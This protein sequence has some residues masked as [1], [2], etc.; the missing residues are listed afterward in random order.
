MPD[1]DETRPETPEAKRLS[2]PVFSLAEDATEADLK[3]AM[4]NAVMSIASNLQYL[5][6]DAEARIAIENVNA[7]DIRKV[8]EAHG[9][10]LTTLERDV[11][12]LKRAAK[13]G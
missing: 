1:D 3:R 12:E 6:E 8:R 9:R 4:A 10:R 13:T 7:A 5:R 2:F 11:A